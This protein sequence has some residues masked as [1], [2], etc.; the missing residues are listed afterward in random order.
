MSAGGGAC[1]AP[2]CLAASKTF[3]GHHVTQGISAGSVALAS[4]QDAAQVISCWGR[5]SGLHCFCAIVESIYMH[6][7]SRSM[8]CACSMLCALHCTEAFHVKQQLDACDVCS[9]LYG[10]LYNSEVCLP[11]RYIYWCNW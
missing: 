2:L 10:D 7:H 5:G 4:R 1:L 3:P 9:N 6:V 11:T 8:L